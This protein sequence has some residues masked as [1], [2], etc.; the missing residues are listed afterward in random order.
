MHL[1]PPSVP[2]LAASHT[3]FLQPLNPTPPPLHPCQRNATFT[4]RPHALPC[5]QW[6]SLSANKPVTAVCL[7]LKANADELKQTND[8]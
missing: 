4:A 6:E 5:K 2:F 7:T 3:N 1:L 8:R